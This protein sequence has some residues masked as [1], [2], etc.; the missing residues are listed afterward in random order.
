MLRTITRRNAT[1]SRPIDSRALHCKIPKLQS[2]YKPLRRPDGSA[3]RTVARAPIE[4][5]ALSATR[6]G[7][8]AFDNFASNLHSARIRSV[9]D[10]ARRTSDLEK[11]GAETQITPA[12][13]AHHAWRLN[14]EN[15]ILKFHQRTDG[16]RSHIQ[17]TKVIISALAASPARPRIRCF[18][19]TMSSSCRSVEILVAQLHDPLVIRQH[20]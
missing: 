11:L 8:S 16:I 7:P 9:E 14:T 18:I 19:A 12:Q 4:H 3:F 1:R 13:Q 20:L 2:A 17:F 6:G 5:R 10:L 15:S